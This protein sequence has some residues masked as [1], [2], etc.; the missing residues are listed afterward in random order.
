MGEAGC[1]IASFE[2]ITVS[3]HRGTIPVMSVM[4]A[5]AEPGW[6]LRVVYSIVVRILPSNS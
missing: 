4:A 5:T 3:L 2:G 1:D 6:G